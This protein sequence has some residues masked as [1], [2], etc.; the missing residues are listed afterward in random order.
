[1]LRKSKLSVAVPKVLGLIWLAARTLSL[2]K[3]LILDLRLLLPPG[4]Y[5]DRK[6]LRENLLVALPRYPRSTKFKQL[7]ARIVK[8]FAFGQQ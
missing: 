3:K 7:L 5:G 1:M 4:E 2:G 6:I 8:T